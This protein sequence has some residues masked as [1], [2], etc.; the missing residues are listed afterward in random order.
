MLCLPRHVEVPPK[1]I[2]PILAEM[3]SSFGARNVALL[4]LLSLDDR[5]AT[6]PHLPFSLFTSVSRPVAVLHFLK[7]YL[8]T[9]RCHL[10]KRLKLTVLHA[11]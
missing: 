5:E 2:E 9:V 4:K 6:Q 7:C 3:H 11:L 1:S 8:I 10:L